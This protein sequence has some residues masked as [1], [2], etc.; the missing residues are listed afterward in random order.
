MWDVNVP[1]LVSVSGSGLFGDVDG[2]KFLFILQTRHFF[3]FKL[4]PNWLIVQIRFN[5]LGSVSNLVLSIL[6]D[7]NPITTDMNCVLRTP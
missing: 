6:Q 1:D 7:L 5:A 4:N 3:W 2:S